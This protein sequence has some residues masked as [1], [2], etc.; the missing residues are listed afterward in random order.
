MGTTHH[1]APKLFYRHSRWSNLLGGNGVSHDIS[2]WSRAFVFAVFF[3][4]AVAFA[5]TTAVLAYEFWD[6]NWFDLATM[7]GHLF[8]FFPTLGIVA[9]FAF[10]VPSAALVDFY[11]RHVPFGR[12]RFAAGSLIL[13]GLSFLIAMSLLASPK[14]SIWEIAPSILTSDQGE[15]ATCAEGDVCE[16]LPMLTA[17]QG[18]RAVSQSR[19][20][21][22]DFVRSC[23]RDEFLESTTGPERKRFCFASTRLTLSPQ[24][25]GD[26][27][28]C[29][30]Q[31]RLSTAISENFSHPDRR[32]LTSKAHALTLPMKVF[33]LLVLLTISIL[34]VTWHRGMEANYRASARRI[35]FSV[36]VGTAAV[37]FF[38]F[39]SQAFV[40]SVSALY[41]LTGRGTFSIITPVLSLAFGIWT[42]L[43]V[44]FFYRR[45]DKDLEAV[46]KMGSAIAAALAV[47]KY[48]VVAAVFTRLLGSGASMA[49]IGGLVVICVA[50]I[51]VLLWL[52]RG[53]TD[54][55][56]VA[57]P[58][59]RPADR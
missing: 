33:F 57:T 27:E 20:G 18:L 36:I 10:Y 48:G 58:G 38:P 30:A 53:W 23:D 11:C 6:S 44:F 26:A 56:A 1:F 47:L 3:V 17:L 37:L 19:W 29:R 7:D 28:C 39:M 41:G 22:G 16:R 46:G 24:L 40:E 34:L 35:E 45:R 49:S 50:A 43:M 15:G 25:Q 21:L 13:C 2:V 32:S 5:A 4:L 9:L 8:I 54:S 52:P 31:Q 55:P 59:D 51:I 12:L 14:R 42:L